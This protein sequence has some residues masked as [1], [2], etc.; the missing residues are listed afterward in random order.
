MSLFLLNFCR[1]CEYSPVADVLNLGDNEG[2]RAV[3]GGGGSALL[4]S[5]FSI[6]SYSVQNRKHSK[7]MKPQRHELL[8]TNGV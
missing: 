6:L 5:Q 7:A 3:S 1:I 8:H 4:L 2:T